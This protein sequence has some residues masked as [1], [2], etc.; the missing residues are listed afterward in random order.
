MLP[1]LRVPFPH[2][3]QPSPY[4]AGE[5]LRSTSQPGDLN[6]T[7]QPKARAED[8]Q[9]REALCSSISLWLATMTLD[10]VEAVDA[11]VMARCR[12]RRNRE[13]AE[14]PLSPTVEA[15]L[16][17]LRHALVVPTRLAPL[18][19]AEMVDADAMGGER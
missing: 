19:E 2:A 7:T 4:G 11:F 12:D 1:R 3:I 14:A 18:W 8:D 6:M 10:D 16:R 9:R 15:G 5:V 17:E 13:L